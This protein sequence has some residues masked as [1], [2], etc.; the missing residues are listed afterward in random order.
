[1]SWA[2]S[3]VNCVGNIEHCLPSTVLKCQG[4]PVVLIVDGPHPSGYEVLSCRRSV[5]FTAAQI[6]VVTAVCSASYLQAS[7]CVCEPTARARLATHVA[8]AMLNG[9]ENSWMTTITYFDVTTASEAVQW[10][11]AV[12]LGAHKAQGHT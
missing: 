5:F 7:Q 1:M 2:A 8:S 10:Y 12:Y 9:P 11:Q 3:A 4:L 6:C